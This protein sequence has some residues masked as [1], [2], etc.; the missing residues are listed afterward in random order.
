MQGSPASWRRVLGAI[1]LPKARSIVTPWVSLVSLLL[2]YICSAI[3]QL[4]TLQVDFPW[5]TAAHVRPL[6]GMPSYGQ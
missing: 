4:R 1:Y 6:I 2:R 5:N 3:M